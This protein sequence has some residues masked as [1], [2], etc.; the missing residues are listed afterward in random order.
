MNEVRLE[1]SVKAEV[2]LKKYQCI[3]PTILYEVFF[4]V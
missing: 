2:L 3:S 1:N 4:M